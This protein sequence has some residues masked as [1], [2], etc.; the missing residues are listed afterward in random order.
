MWPSPGR[1]A[2][3]PTVPKKGGPGPAGRTPKTTRQRSITSTPTKDRRFMRIVGEWFLC[4][5]TVTRPIVKGYVPNASG[6]DCRER[7]LVDTGA[8]RTVFTA[9][10]LAKLNLPSVA[11][12]QSIAL[13]GV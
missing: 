12:P 7:F 8:D 1:K 4:T 11:A 6:T 3:S 5:D 9:G 10:F 2:L 13:A